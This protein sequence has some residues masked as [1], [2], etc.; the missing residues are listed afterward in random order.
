MG[1]GEPGPTSE[2]FRWE[3]ETTPHR[4]DVSRQLPPSLRVTDIGE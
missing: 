3:V 4:S 1:P 2:S